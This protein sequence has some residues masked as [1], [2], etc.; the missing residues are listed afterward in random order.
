MFYF[1]PIWMPLISFLLSLIA[2]GGLSSIMVNRSNKDKYLR[3]E[4]CSLLPLNIMLTVGF[5]VDAIYQL[6]NCPPFCNLL[7]VFIINR[8]WILSHAFSALLKQS[9]SGFV[10]CYLWCIR[11]IDFRMS[12]QPCIPE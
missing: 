12:N 8:C 7:R 2:L 9:N 3:G 1:F 6:G 11:L 10:F 4:V 5:F